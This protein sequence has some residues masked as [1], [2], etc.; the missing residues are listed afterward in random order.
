LL[1]IIIETQAIEGQIKVTE[2]KE[3]IIEV[4]TIEEI[5]LIEQILTNLKEV[6][7]TE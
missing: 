1:I 4:K 6:I 5:M 3:T 2:L 7:L